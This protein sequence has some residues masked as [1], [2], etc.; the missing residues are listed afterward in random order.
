MSSFALR[1]PEFRQ[2]DSRLALA[3]LVFGAL[4]IGTTPILVRLAA[5]GPAAAGFWRLAFATPLLALMASGR[6]AASIGLPTRAMVLAGI[7]FALDLAC[8]HYGIRYTSVANA[9]V[10]PNLTPVLV[11]LA[12]WLFFKERPR[13]LFVVG[14]VAAV[15]GAV[16]MAETGPASPTSGPLPHIGDA[17]SVSTALWYGLYFM[18]VRAARL[19]RSTLSVMLWSCLIG[20][21]PLLLTAVVMREPLLPATSLGWAAVV[22]LGLA[23]VFGQGS[24]A[25]ALG[26]LP[27]S[28]ASVTVLVQPVFAATLAYLL[29]SEVLTPWQ[30]A[31]GLLALVGVVF[32]Q[33]APARS[34]GASPPTPE[35]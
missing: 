34:V 23:H 18:S 17:L 30:T 20:A 10:L 25:W 1:R 21:P 31:G 11:T 5:C 8:W 3:A 29:F 6:G 24:I 22:G 15:G 7:F 16:L 4:V 32:A 27:A 13:P 28:T 26:R 19:A 33:Q 9:T 2:D 35:R 12:S 14:L